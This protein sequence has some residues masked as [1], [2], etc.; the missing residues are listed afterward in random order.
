MSL[1]G[2]LRDQK[3]FYLLEPKLQMFAC[4]HMRS[5]PLL[6]IEPLPQPQIMVVLML[7]FNIKLILL[8]ILQDVASHVY[9]YFIKFVQY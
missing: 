7:M 6:D 3:A 8:K 2:V 4:L 1:P 9:D 5:S